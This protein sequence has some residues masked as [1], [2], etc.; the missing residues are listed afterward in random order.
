MQWALHPDAEPSAAALGDLTAIYHAASGETHVVGAAVVALLD[1][2][3]LG[4][5]DEE[6]L[7]RASGLSADRLPSELLAL[8]DAGLIAPA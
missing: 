1:R 3:G 6:E 7:A 2:L 4:P 5:A 8:L